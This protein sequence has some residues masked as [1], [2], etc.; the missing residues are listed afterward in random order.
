MLTSIFIF[1][2]LLV[3]VL[4]IFFF[5]LKRAKWLR[6]GEVVFSF[7]RVFHNQ[8]SS[9]PLLLIA[10]KGVAEDLF[11]DY[12]PS[13]IGEILEDVGAAHQGY[14]HRCHA[15]SRRTGT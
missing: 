6:F 5:K 7:K 8:L 11:R 4:G 10:I 3:Q 9:I 1:K 2:W 12:I 15:S 13:F 14:H